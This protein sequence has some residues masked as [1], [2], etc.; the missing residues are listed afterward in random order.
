VEKALPPQ[1][2]GKHGAV[3]NVLSLNMLGGDVIA[4]IVANSLPPCI[5]VVDIAVI[6]AA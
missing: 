2:P 6:N 4:K 3:K 1:T 5:L